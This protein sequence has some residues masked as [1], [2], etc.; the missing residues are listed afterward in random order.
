MADITAFAAVAA[1]VASVASTSLAVVGARNVNA[2]KKI[3]MRNAQ[4]A[5][6]QESEALRVREE[7][8][9][10]A[11]RAA[12]MASG[13]AIDSASS[14]AFFAASDQAGD[15]DYYNALLNA[16]NRAGSIGASA[17]ALRNQ[18][19]G[20]AFK[21]ASQGI[22]AYDRAINRTP[23]LTGGLVTPRVKGIG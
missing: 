9:R 6:M 21:S 1:A 22:T 4:L 16:G 3:D 23:K 12:I 19:I 11:N 18:H 2:Q 13:G 5:G 8:Q 7:R 15:R 14:R 17:D 20:S 10:G